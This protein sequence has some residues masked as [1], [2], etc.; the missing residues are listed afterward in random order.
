[1]VTPNRIATICEV[2]TAIRCG[3]SGMYG[4]GKRSFRHSSRNFSGDRIPGSTTTSMP[5]AGPTRS[6]SFLRSGSV[7]V[8]AKL[9]IPSRQP[10]GASAV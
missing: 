5:S 8:S 7:I 3:V 6:A 9:G 1:M 2:S 4:F 10:Y